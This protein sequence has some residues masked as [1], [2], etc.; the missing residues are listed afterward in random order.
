MYVTPER[1]RAAA[2]CDHTPPQPTTITNADRSFWSPVSVRKTRFRA[3]CSRMSSV[4]KLVRVSLGRMEIY[5]PT[6]II[7]PLLCPRRKSSTPLILLT[8]PRTRCCHPKICKL[9]FFYQHF[10]SKPPP[11]KRELN[12]PDH[13]HPIPH[14][15]S[16][17]S[18][19]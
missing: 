15:E 4:A 14:P 19:P 10:S 18:N 11:H 7:I 3:N 12:P 2:Q 16:H 13:H 17:S 9:H 8:Q 1:A 5:K 6:V